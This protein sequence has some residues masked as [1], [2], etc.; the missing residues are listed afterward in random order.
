MTPQPRGVIPEEHEQALRDA[1]TARDRAEEQLHTAVADALKAGGS[2][3][4][5][6]LFT[7]LSTNTVQRWG[8]EG[9][10]PTDAQRKAWAEAKAPLDEFE[11]RLR[12]SDAMVRRVDPSDEA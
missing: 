5:V 1:L 2:V 11:A 10:W 3:R 12:V 9:G 6:A 8:R 7:G 4:Q